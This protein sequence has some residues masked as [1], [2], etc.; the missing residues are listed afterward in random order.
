MTL[1]Q[2]KKYK[3]ELSELLKQFP[4]V[5]IIG[6]RQCG[7]T[8]L[9]KSIKYND[10]FDLENPRDKA[11]LSE[12]QL[13][14]E[15]TKG[16][17][18]IDE[19]QLQPELFSLLR[20]LVDSKKDLRFLILGSASPEL[21]KKSSQSLAGRIAYIELSP[22]SLNEINEPFSNL[23]NRGGYPNS[24][25]AKT[26][27]TSFVW[28][29]NYIRTFLERDIPQLGINIPSDTLRRFWV[30]IAHYHG[31]VLNFSE[32][33]RSFGINDVT[34]RNYLDILAGTFMIE[35]LQ[36]WCANIKKR[37]VK[38]PKLYIRDSGIF[39]SL[40]QIESIKSLM[41]NPKLGASFEGFVIEQITRIAPFSRKN[42]YFWS[43]HTG[44][45]LDLFW[46]YDGKKYGVEIKYNDAPKLTKS[47]KIAC[48]DLKLQHLWVV[49]PG[50]Q[51]YKLTENISV[52]PVTEI[53]NI[54]NPKFR[55]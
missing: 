16:L 25:L 37:Q 3:A 10:F 53:N 2:R 49:Y 48:E 8:T 21:I 24:L 6:P 41:S 47:M 11:R 20:F 39:H 26:D 5:A 12:P 33:G 30:M 36:P 38:R 29:E 45:E 14:L 46:I 32:L 28:R 54:F 7:K 34:V 52:I 17:V 4:I 27:K 23:W 13:A 31:Q 42:F 43:V 15:N 44:S 9:A 22:F 51:K 40:L 18:V 19:V 55:I 50:N 1:I 35:L